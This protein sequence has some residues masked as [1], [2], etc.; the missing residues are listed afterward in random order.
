MCLDELKGYSGYTTN[1][2]LTPFASTFKK[3]KKEAKIKEQQGKSTILRAY[4]GKNTEMM[5]KVNG[6]FCVS[7]HMEL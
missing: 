2:R 5:L 1:F 4:R 3:W 7:S 6:P